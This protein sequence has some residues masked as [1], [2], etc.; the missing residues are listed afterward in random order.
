MG[1]PLDEDIAELG[2]ADY[3]EDE[4]LRA[5]LDM[6]KVACDP[7]GSGREFLDDVFEK[8]AE[9][10]PEVYAEVLKRFD[11][12]EGLDAGWDRVVP[13]PWA[14]TFGVKTAS[15]VWEEGAERVTDDALINLAQNY[16]P[17]LTLEWSDEFADEFRKDP[18]GVFN[19]LPT[20]QKKILSRLASDVESDGGTEYGTARRA[21]G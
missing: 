13:D 6:R 14:S 17:R 2:A 11:I 9:L 15:V 3:A 12:E 21:N 1:Y 10:H 20:P 5:A 7:R 8:R 16:S 18:V 4:Q 19:S